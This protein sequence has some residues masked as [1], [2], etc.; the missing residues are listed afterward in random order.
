MASVVFECPHC[1]GAMEAEQGGLRGRLVSCPHCQA[2]VQLPDADEVAAQQ[3]VEEQPE[4]QEAPQQE[5]ESSGGADSLS[6]GT[7]I[8]GIY[9]IERLLGSSSIG[10]VYVGT[11][12]TDNRKVQL[13]IIDG[14]EQETIE[15][16]S[17]EIELL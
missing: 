1:G 8:R 14:R 10:Q 9:K 12:T 2:Q 11:I 7:V 15:R 17:R 5:A 6:A 16:L 4:A 3:A 13:E